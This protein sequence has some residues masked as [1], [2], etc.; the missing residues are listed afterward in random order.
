VQGDVCVCTLES[1]LNV[2]EKNFPSGDTLTV[3]ILYCEAPMQL[4]GYL[5]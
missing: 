4:L 1:T 3:S 2:E 5:E